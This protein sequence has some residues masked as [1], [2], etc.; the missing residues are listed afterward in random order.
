MNENDQSVDSEADALDKIVAGVSSN[1]SKNSS[2]QHPSASDSGVDI[3]VDSDD[4]EGIFDDDDD[5]DVLRTADGAP[6]KPLDYGGL[7]AAGANAIVAPVQKA[8][9]GD[10]S[11][12]NDD[13]SQSSDRSDNDDHDGDDADSDSD[14]DEKKDKSGNGSDSGEDYTDDED[15]GEDGYR[16]GGYHP[17][18]VGEI[19]N[20]RY[21]RETK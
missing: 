21:E 2:T 5:D 18:K 3:I 9:A 11:S 15:E 14:R 10:D 12:Q 20:Q 13:S 19:Y 4:E 7:L 16:P 6:E 8:I 1:L 17:V